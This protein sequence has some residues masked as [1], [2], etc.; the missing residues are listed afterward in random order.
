MAG[1]FAPVRIGEADIGAARPF[2]EV[3]K[4]T[5][6]E[7]FQ[8]EKSVL[9]P[10]PVIRLN[11]KDRVKRTEAILRAGG[12]IRPSNSPRAPVN[13]Y[14]HGMLIADKIVTLLCLLAGFLWL[15]ERARFIKLENQMGKAMLG[16][17]VLLPAVLF[18]EKYLFDT[19]HFGAYTD[20]ALKAVL[21]L[22]PFPL[23]GF[24]LLKRQPSAP[25]EAQPA[26]GQ[27]AEP[28]AA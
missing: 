3:L 21:L 6:T 14:L 16:V 27:S 15:R 25:G 23:I 12:R 10:I 24:L 5:R 7:S 28:P 4:Y 20:L 9:A 18:G 2:P 8:P 19:Y 17:F 26:S 11:I 13:S 22:L 1:K